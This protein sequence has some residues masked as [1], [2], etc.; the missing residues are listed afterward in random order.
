MK[1]LFIS[2]FENMLLFLKI[3]ENNSTMQLLKIENNLKNKLCQSDKKLY[4]EKADK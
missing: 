2:V 1:S 4:N 3:G